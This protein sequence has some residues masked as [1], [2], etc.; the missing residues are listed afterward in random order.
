MQ[1]SGDSTGAA[2]ALKGAIALDSGDAVAWYQLALLDAAA[3][4][5]KEAAEKAATAIRLDPDL[6]DARNSLG[7]GLAELGD[8]GG[9]EK[10]FREALLVDPNFATAH[11]NL[12]RL[13]AAKGDSAAALT[14]FAKAVRL[15]P[16]FAPDRHEYALA[17]VRASRFPEARS[18]VEAAILLAPGFVEVRILSGGLWARE[19]KL[20]PA[21]REYEEAIRIRPGSGRAHLDLARVLIAMGDREGTIAHLRLA[22]ASSDAASAGLARQALRNLGAA[23]E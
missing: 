9:A 13:L 7:A 18:E 11:G 2:A 15:R 12:A 4:R 21:R 17:L 6:L 1:E 16:D 10:A 20:E 5:V 14:H 23:L 3:G 19:G 8:Q 22:A